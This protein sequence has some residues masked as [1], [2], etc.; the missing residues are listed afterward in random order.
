MAPRDDVF[1][2]LNHKDGP[3]PWIEIRVDN[4]IAGKAVG[5]ELNCVNDVKDWIAMAQKVGMS[6]ANV[7]ALNRFGTT[8]RKTRDALYSETVPLLTDWAAVEKI[9]HP[10]PVEGE[11]IAKIKRAGENQ[12]REQLA[13]FGVALG[14]VDPTTLSMGFEHFFTS[15]YDDRKLVETVLDLYTDYAVALVEIYSASPG[16][17]II[18]ITDDMAY[19]SGPFVGPC[20]FRELLLPRYKR[21]ANSIKKP[22]MLHSDGDLRPVLGD[23]LDLGIKGLHPIQPGPMDILE[24][25]KEIGDRVFLAGN[26][27]LDILA[28]GTP[29]QVKAE[30]RWLAELCGKGGGYMLSSSNSIADWLKLENF[31]AMGEALQEFNKSKS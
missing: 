7:R 16:I 31:L 29:A 10:L 13:V 18:W 14:F 28:R 3:I 26:V 27:N 8:E 21:L 19:D 11:I 23:L 15:I 2:A 24:L 12:P 5:R 9:G 20:L 17:D 6:C 4:E 1:N 22:W 25:K 30:V